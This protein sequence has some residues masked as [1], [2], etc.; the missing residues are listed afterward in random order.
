M[1]TCEPRVDQGLM[2][3]LGGAPNGNAIITREVEGQ[4]PVLL[5]GGAR[6]VSTGG[7]AMDDTEAPLGVKLTYRV[8]VSG[9]SAPDRIVQ[10]NLALTPTFTHGVQ[11]WLTGSAAGRSLVIEADTTAHSAQVG[12]FIGSTAGTAPPAA[13]TLVGHVDSPM[14]TNA[15]YSL[16]APITGGAASDTYSNTYADSY[17]PVAPGAI[18]T[19]DWLLLVHQQLAAAAASAPVPVGTGVWSLIDDT[20]NGTLRQMIWAMKRTANDQAGNLGVQVTVANGANAIGT[21]LWIRGATQD[22]II[23]SPVTI[24]P[25]YRDYLA[26]PSASI[27]RPHL[28]LSFMSAAMG[29][30]GVVPTSGS[31]TGGTLQYVR[32]GVGDPR[33]LTVVS[34][35][36]AQASDTQQTVVDYDDLVTAGVAV[37]LSLQAP[38][39]LTNRIIARGKLAALPHVPQPYLL[40]GRLRFNSIDLNSWQD[41]KTF[42][43]WQQVRT[44]KTTWLDVRGSSSQTNDEFLSL[45]A[46]IVDPATG[47]DYITPARIYNISG[48]RLNTWIDFS[49]LF[50]TSAAIPA[51]AELRLF[52]GTN[53]REYATDIWLDEVGVTPGAQ[54]FGH[55]TL[56]WFD[57]DTPLPPATASYPYP[58]WIEDSDDASIAWTG[59][60]GNSVSV[61]TGPSALH[62]TT[63]C[64]LDQSDSARILPCEPVLISD[65]VNVTLA[66]WM[67]LIA[68]DAL[69]H[70]AKMTVHQIINRAAPV[71]ISQVRGWETGTLTLMTM[72]RAQ[73]EQVLNVIRSG[74]V[75]LLRNPIPDYP[76]NN[77][78]LALGDITEDRPIPNQRVTVR[79]WTVPFVRVERPAGLIEAASGRS[80]QQVRDL[81]TWDTIRNTQQDWLAALAGESVS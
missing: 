76:E 73:R 37:Q 22:Q 67:G 78:F 66:I 35:T 24:A 60:V 20:T 11:G 36:G 58:G 44:A 59:A 75:V 39:S 28:T 68:I 7:V 51:T 56:H 45:F 27:T 40:T 19:N 48:S 77:W 10:Q 41:I 25:G 14:F 79:E 74:R 30:L 26:T 38:A 29:P 4:S 64:Q 2:R 33:T 71:V 70:P 69:R 23:K 16:Q 50:N 61:F 49:A 15:N 34:D 52:H 72:N 9:L 63:S 21:L 47:S 31:V 18:A 55:P 6:V 1:I 5:R 53:V 17:G 13:P 65:P 3:I 80:W 43:T 62:A 12:H 46:A 81:G 42:G 54:F 8:A 57:G 32:S